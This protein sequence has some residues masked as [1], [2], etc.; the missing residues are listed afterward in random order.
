MGC[1][2]NWLFWTIAGVVGGLYVVGLRQRAKTRQPSVE[3]IEEPEATEAY[4]RIAQLPQFQL[5]REIIARR[6]VDGWKHARVLDVGSGPGLLSI[7]L[8]QLSGVDGVTGIDLSTDMVEAAREAA[9]LHGVNAQFL[10]ADAADMP[11]E[12]A[13]FDVVVSTLSMHHWDD[14]RAV[15]REIHRVLAPG[16]QALIFDLRRDAFPLV[17]GVATVASRFIMPEELRKFGEPV[18]S[19]QAAYTPCEAILLAAKAGWEDPHVIQGPFWMV[20]ELD[21]SGESS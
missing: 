18:N 8:A 7:R 1:K 6:A 19:F 15:L 14:A 4:T 13:A 2:R 10:Q 17:L 21:K 3:A 11:F 5:A 20:L 9:E 16:G 12:D